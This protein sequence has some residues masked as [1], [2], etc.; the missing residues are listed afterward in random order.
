MKVNNFAELHPEAYRL[1]VLRAAYIRLRQIASDDLDPII[2]GN[3]PEPNDK[4]GQFL[5]KCTWKA[6]ENAKLIDRM[7]IDDQQMR[8]FAI[9][10][11]KARIALRPELGTFTDEGNRYGRATKGVQDF[12]SQVFPI[13]IED[14]PGID[15]STKEGDFRSSEAFENFTTWLDQNGFYVEAGS[16]KAWKVERDGEVYVHRDAGL[17]VLT[18]PI[19]WEYSVFGLDEVDRVIGEYWEASRERDSDVDDV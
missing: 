11:E 14:L 15:L 16:D 3:G 5:V 18:K 10:Y 6:V 13:S 1:A 8:D 17:V 4:V 9:E 7:I 12:V 2:N 19:D